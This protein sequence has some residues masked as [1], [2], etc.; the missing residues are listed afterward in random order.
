[1][2]TKSIVII[3][4]EEQIVQDQM[5]VEFHRIMRSH[6]SYFGEVDVMLLSEKE[7]ASAIASIASMGKNEKLIN[8]QVKK[9]DGSNTVAKRLMCIGEIDSTITDLEEEYGD[10]QIMRNLFSLYI[11]TINDPCRHML[12]TILKCREFDIKS[13]AVKRDVAAFYAGTNAK[14]SYL[15]MHFVEWVQ[16]QFAD[17]KIEIS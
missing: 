15:F 4:D 10:L 8:K 9:L 16:V 3:F 7:M 17:L 12:S 14:R 11:K 2:K 1:M 5:I 13:P 6:M